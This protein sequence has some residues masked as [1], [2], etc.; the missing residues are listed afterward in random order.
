MIIKVIGADYSACGIGKIDIPVDITDEVKNIMS[1][2]SVKNNSTN[3]KA[4]Q[5][6]FN[7]VSSFKKKIKVLCLPIFAST[8]HEAVTNV[9]TNLIVTEQEPGS[10]IEITDSGSTKISANYTGSNFVNVITKDNKDF[11]SEIINANSAQFVSFKG[12][13]N[14]ALYGNI[15]SQNSAAIGILP[16]IKETETLGFILNEDAQFAYMGDDRT[17]TD[18]AYNKTLNDKKNSSLAQSY[19]FGRTAEAF[20][21]SIFCVTTGMTVDEYQILHKAMSSLNN[22]TM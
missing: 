8:S 16:N 17:L 3:Q 18:F 4:L 13:M 12:S 14:I 1:T 7:S 20:G 2:F 19:P 15:I 21:C 11:S 5:K 10:F 22:L 6:F 9:M